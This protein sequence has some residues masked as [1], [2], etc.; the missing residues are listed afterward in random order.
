MLG[1]SA[2]P[3]R[4]VLFEFA[5]VC[6]V[7]ACSGVCGMPRTKYVFTHTK[8]LGKRLQKLIHLVES[9]ILLRARRKGAALRLRPKVAC[10][11]LVIYRGRQ[12]VL[13]SVIL[14]D[15]GRCDHSDEH[16]FDHGRE[17][18]STYQTRIALR[19]KC[20]AV[21]IRAGLGL[22]MNAAEFPDAEDVAKVHVHKL[23]S[24]WRSRQ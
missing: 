24:P 6:L 8:V 14:P 11:L 13:R 12:H 16:L 10:G 17:P 7:N 1:G 15:F 20:G 22:D 4:Y 19:T 21:S 18:S 3:L 5:A 23:R 9:D 2:C